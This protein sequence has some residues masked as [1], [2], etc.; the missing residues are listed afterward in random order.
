MTS[1]NASKNWLRIA[2]FVSGLVS[3]TSPSSMRNASS[4]GATYDEPFQYSRALTMSSSSA[5]SSLY[6]REP[7]LR[8]R[9]GRALRPDF[10]AGDS[11]IE[12]RRSRT[13]RAV[14]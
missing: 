5:R 10:R 6:I 2:G 14:K 11:G 13:R 3:P 1:L 8:R 9:P 7:Y 12:R 4:T